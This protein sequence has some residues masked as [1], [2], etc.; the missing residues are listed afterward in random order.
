MLDIH[1]FHTWNTA[2]LVK[3]ERVEGLLADVA[4]LLLG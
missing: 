3:V 4:H 2:R 1:G